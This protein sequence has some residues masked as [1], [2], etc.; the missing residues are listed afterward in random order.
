[1]RRLFQG[2]Q[3]KTKPYNEKEIHQ[4]EQEEINTSI[5]NSDQEFLQSP[6]ISSKKYLAS[7]SRQKFI[8]LSQ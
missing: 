6:T 3:N 4:K 7:V 2:K 5:P 8:P 1:M